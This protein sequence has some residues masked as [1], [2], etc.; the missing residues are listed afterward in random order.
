[1]SSKGDEQA[2]HKVESILVHPKYDSFYSDYD[3]ALVKLSTEVTIS[4]K[5]GIICLPSDEFQPYD[6][7][8][9]IVTGWGTTSSGGKLSNGNNNINFEIIYG[10]L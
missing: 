4:L 2:Y 7:I 3:F 9:L 6:G 1:L 10:M 8:A 5:A